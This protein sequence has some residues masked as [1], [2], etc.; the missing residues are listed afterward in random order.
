MKKLRRKIFL[1]AAIF[2]VLMVLFLVI[3]HFRGKVSLAKYKKALNAKG[4][5]LSV[6]ELTPQIPEGANGAPVFLRAAGQLRDGNAI[7]YFLPPAMRV[8]APGHAIVGHRQA[9]WVDEDYRTSRTSKIVTNN[10]AGLAQDL[11]KNQETLDAI[12]AALQQP[13][14]DARLDYSRGFE[15]DVGYWMQT[16]S[17]AQWLSAATLNDLHNGDTQKAL[18]NLQALSGLVRLHHND[19]ILIGQLVR[20]AIASIEMSAAWEALQADGW[21]DS[22]WARLQHILQTGDFIGDTARA[23]EMERAIGQTYYDRFRRSNHEAAEIARIQRTTFFPD[24]DDEGK[25]LAAVASK[26]PYGEE[27]FDF[28]SSNIGEP[29]VEF[30]YVPFWQ[31][32][33][34]YQD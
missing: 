34:S 29:F 8:V 25:G 3:E 10:W 6:H 19:P 1:G 9:E 22:Q 21:T 20:I 23:L 26:L 12:R 15:F 5:K 16:K 13:I 30:V 2:F 7:R 28:F 4:E 17:T 31:F 11:E 32:S 18:E 33:W 14:L 24:E 27:I